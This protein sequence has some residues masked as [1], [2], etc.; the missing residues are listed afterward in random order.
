M[1]YEPYL[2]A[3]LRTG[4]ELDKKPW[5]LPKDAFSDM[6]NAFL[7]DGVLQKRLGYSLFTDT[8]AGN[9]I[10][11]IFEYVETDG[12]KT[13][14]VADTRRLYEYSGGSLVDRDGSDQWTGDETHLLSVVQWDGTAYMANGRDQTRTW[15]GTTAADLVADLDSDLANDVDYCSFLAIH[16]ERLI[17]FRPSESGTLC[18]QRARWCVAADP[19]D[20]T[21]DEYL[22]AP[23]NEW[24]RGIA[25]LGDDII[26]WFDA[27]VWMFRYT[28]DSAA[29]FRWDRISNEEGCLAGFSVL[30]KGDRVI[31]LGKAGLVTTDGL[32]AKRFDDLIPDFALTFD[33]GKAA[34]CV[35]HDLED[36]RQAWLLYPENGEDTPNMALVW[37]YA[38]GSWARF[39]MPMIC[40]GKYSAAEA[41]TWGAISGTW[42]AQMGA[43]GSAGTQGGYP[44]VLAGD[45]SGYVY[46]LNNTGADNSGSIEMVIESGRWNPY[47]KQGRRARMG[48]IDLLVESD[49][50]TEASVGLYLDYED[51]P[52]QTATLSFDQ[53]GQRAWVR[54]FSGAAGAFHR[55]K[56]MH[57]AANQP[58]QIHAIMPWFAPM[59]GRLYG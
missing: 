32:A 38:D 58:V 10:V 5:L 45:M 31:A 53:T 17:M 54:I 51:A 33:Q 14:M 59:G 18:P 19:T 35:I 8:A 1:R 48:H 15:D 56:I 11:G 42:A 3:D 27:S 34:Q 22:D 24:I 21:N 47:S 29:P 23:T 25:H 2:I 30:N 49:S 6:K 26:V 46:R 43:W 57:T 4:L 44:I 16:K 41:S 12:S 9:P 37:N 28:A 39:D 7:R 40:F 36:Q 55:I 13:L 50:R 52:Y 20:W